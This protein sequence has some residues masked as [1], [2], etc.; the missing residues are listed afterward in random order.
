MR[1]WTTE[2]R[3]YYEQHLRQAI[4]A[5]NEASRAIWTILGTER[6]WEGTA[7]PGHN[8]DEPAALRDVLAEIEGIDGGFYWIGH[9]RHEWAMDSLILLLEG[10]C[11]CSA[12]GEC[13]LPASGQIELY[14]LRDGLKGDDCRRG[15]RALHRVC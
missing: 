7:T 2:D 5:L 6:L 14:T 3:A 1:T 13:T 11:P 4:A 9:G 8:E 15:R 12:C 10:G